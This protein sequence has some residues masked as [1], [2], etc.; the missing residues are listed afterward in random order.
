VFEG[1][2][3]CEIFIFKSQLVNGLR[4]NPK[5]LHNKENNPEI[6]PRT[7]IIFG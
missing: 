7:I 2:I 4:I 5:K 3:T 1:N 6:P